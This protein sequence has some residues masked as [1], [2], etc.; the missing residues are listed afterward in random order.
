MIGVWNFRNNADEMWQTSTQQPE[1]CYEKRH[2]LPCPFCEGEP[3]PLDENDHTSCMTIWCGSTAYMHVDAWNNRP[4]IAAYQRIE[5]LEAELGGWSPIEDAP[6]SGCKVDL[7]VRY[8]RGGWQRVA[9]AH[10]NEKLNGWQL[11][12]HNVSDFMVP[13]V[14]THFMM[15]PGPPSLDPYPDDASEDDY[16]RGAQADFESHVQHLR[17][18]REWE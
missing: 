8:D 12:D 10:W 15:P 7:W 14:I 1:V 5:E 13:P 17:S 9:D 16:Q 18:A 6:K 2:V 3:A 11:G 4:T